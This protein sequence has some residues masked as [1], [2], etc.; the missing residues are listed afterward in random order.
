MP[1]G[2][3][4]TAAQKALPDDLLDDPTLVAEAQR[5]C[6][7]KDESPCLGPVTDCTPANCSTVEK[8]WKERAHG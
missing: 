1:E 7:W 5:R 2:Q 8:V 4:M 6:R 3:N